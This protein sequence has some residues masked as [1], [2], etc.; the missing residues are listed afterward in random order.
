VLQC[1]D[2]LSSVFAYVQLL[3]ICKI[4]N[5]NRKSTS[6]LNNELC[7]IRWKFLGLQAWETESQETLRELVQRGKG[8]SQVTWKFCNK[9][10]V[11]LRQKIDGLQVRHLQLTSC[12]HFTGQEEVGFRQDTYY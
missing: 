10:Q 1:C 2:D 8:R 9:E 12:L 7:L 11:V 4:L 3:D 5:V 6:N